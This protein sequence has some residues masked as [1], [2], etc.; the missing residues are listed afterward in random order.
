[1]QSDRP[2]NLVRIGIPNPVN[3]K[4]EPGEGL[5]FFDTLE[6]LKAAQA[7]RQLTKRRPEDHND[8]WVRDR[9]NIFDPNRLEAVRRAVEQSAVILEHWYYKGGASPDRFF[10]YRFEDFIAYLEQHACSGDKIRVWSFDLCTL[11]N[12]IASGICP[13]DDGYMP[14]AGAY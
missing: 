5:S 13:D 1:M 11:D 2:T 7:H 4:L 9:P 10:F 6:H 8:P 3:L 12:V 14:V